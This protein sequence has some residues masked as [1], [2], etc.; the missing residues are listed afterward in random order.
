M[1][2]WY[3][4]IV[5]SIQMRSVFG[6]TAGVL[7]DAMLGNHPQGEPSGSADGVTDNQLVLL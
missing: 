1:S 3:I 2:V 4:G 6:S 7:I 5:H